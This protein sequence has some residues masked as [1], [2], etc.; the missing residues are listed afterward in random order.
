MQEPFDP[1]SNNTGPKIRWDGPAAKEVID[2]LLA[3]I[4]HWV[5]ATAATFH[6]N[7]S[8]IRAKNE[9][10]SGYALQIESAALKVKHQLTR[11]LSLAPLR[12]LVHTMRTVWNYYN[13]DDPLPVDAVYD[14]VIPDYGSA[15]TLREEVDADVLLLEK[16]IKTL[17]DL[18]LKYNP[19]ISNEKVE[20]ML[21]ED[22]EE[23][24]ASDPNEPTD[25]AEDQ[26]ED[27][28][29]EPPAVPDGES[30]DTAPPV[31]GKKPPAVPG[32]E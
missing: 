16:G 1:L 6:L 31:A 12:R 26:K 14:V 25:P 24:S 11:T 21:A 15:V 20:Q 2:A 7:P 27:L 10:T 4:G 18:I 13:P 19:G 22:D 23:D 9:A 8:A 5:E 17:E 28:T 30:G 32:E 29:E 3:V